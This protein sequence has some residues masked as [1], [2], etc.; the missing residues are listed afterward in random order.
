VSC[1]DSRGKRVLSGVGTFGLAATAPLGRAECAPG[2]LKPI[3]TVVRAEAEG[4]SSSS[5][6]C[7]VMDGKR[8]PVSD[9]R[10]SLG[11]DGPGKGCWARRGEG[12]GEADM[13]RVDGDVQWEGEGE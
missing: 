3:T 2:G 12:D 6:G 9:V 7:D 13:S 11:D 10:G 8:V 5:N 1:G 4:E